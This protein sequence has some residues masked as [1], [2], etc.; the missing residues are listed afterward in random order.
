MPLAGLVL[1]RVHGSDAARLST[2]DALAAAENLDAFGIVDQSGGK[3]APRDPADGPLDPPDGSPEAVPEVAPD[4]VVASGPAATTDTREEHEKHEELGKEELGTTEDQ[5]DP[6]EPACPGPEAT[7][8]AMATPAAS[9][10]APDPDP[11]PDADATP[12]APSA[13]APASAD[14]SPQ[15][16]AHADASVPASVDQLAAALLRLHAE[17][18]QVVARERRTR[19][20]FTASHPEVPVTEVAA[21]PGDVHDLAGLRSIGDRLAAGTAGGGAA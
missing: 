5:D 17:R 6:A 12:S 2:E 21:L 11:G 3:A 19:D 13:P 18:M 16:P 14:A 7:P 20:S 10:P 15:A 1:N 9:D 4:T 8:E